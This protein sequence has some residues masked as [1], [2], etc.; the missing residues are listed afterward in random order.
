MELSPFQF[1][2]IVRFR[3]NFNALIRFVAVSLRY[4][5]IEIDRELFKLS[6]FR[7]GIKIL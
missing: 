7:N 5:T 3:F 1:E 6:D 2:F 4:R